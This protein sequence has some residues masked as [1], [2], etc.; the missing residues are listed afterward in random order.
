[1]ND[2]RQTKTDHNRSS[3]AK[4]VPGF[5]TKGQNGKQLEKRKIDLWFL[6][7]KLTLHIIPMYL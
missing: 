3:Q 5:H 1:M 2:G 4:Y 7:T 6:C